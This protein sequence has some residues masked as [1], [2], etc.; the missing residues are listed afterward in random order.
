MRRLASRSVRPGTLGGL[1]LLIGLALG[2]RPVPADVVAPLVPDAAVAPDAGGPLRSR[3][4][5][6]DWTP[7]MLDGQ[8]RFLPDF[9]YAGYRNGEQELP[10]APGGPLLSVVDYGADPTAGRDS[11]AAIQA[12]IDA[13]GAAGGG[14]VLLP[15]GRYRCDGVLTVDRSGVVVRGAGPEQTFVQFT[16]VQGM[17][18]AAHLTVHGK[19]SAGAPLA[20]AADGEARSPVVQC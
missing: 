1:G 19:L 4:Y 17:S 5:P 7:G 2:C 3:L 15:A 14:I 16:R 11:T 9:S 18:Y 20:L 8:G 10:T 6:S 13:A 12:A